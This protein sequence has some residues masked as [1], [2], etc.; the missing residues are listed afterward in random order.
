MESHPMKQTGYAA[1]T[2]VPVERSKAEIERLL[3]KYGAEGYHTGW[4]AAAGED[5]GWDVVEFVWKSKQ[6]R[7]RLDR[8]KAKIAGKAQGWAVGRGGYML[9]GGQL[10]A[11]I[12]QRNRQRWRVLCLV[13]KAKLE[14]VEAGVGIF[15]DEFL[16]FIVTAS[17]RTIGEILV[18]RLAAQGGRLQLEAGP[19]E[20]SV[21]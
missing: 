17:G 1:D 4:Q 10:Q 3:T 16:S 5:P 13:I 20:A 19:V 21:G 12:D 8:P 7:F 11:A 14:A 2:T 18:P 9:S 15:E 6:I